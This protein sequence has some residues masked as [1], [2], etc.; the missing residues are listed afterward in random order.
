MARDNL[1]ETEA[2]QRIDAQMPLSEKCRKADFIVDNSNE[3][4]LTRQHTYTLF[5]QMQ[6]L[7]YHQLM[8]RKFLLLLVGIGILYCVNQ[9]YQYF[10]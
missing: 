4:E 3:K 5:G 7:S 10:G 2:L 9:L 8:L 6:R 1:S